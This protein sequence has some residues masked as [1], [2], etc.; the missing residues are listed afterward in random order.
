MLEMM[1]HKVSI[2]HDGNVA[3]DLAQ[4]IH[5]DVIMLDIGLPGLNGYE[6]CQKLRAMPGFANTVF[7]A[8]TGWGQESDKKQ[9][10]DAGF[11]HHI[12]KPISFEEFSELLRDIQRGK[13]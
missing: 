12:V 1:G 11:H 3:V 7:I 6:V 10:F 2:G 4:K 13:A 8:Q 9:A 5:P